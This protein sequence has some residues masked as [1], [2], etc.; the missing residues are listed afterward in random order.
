MFLHTFAH[1]EGQVEAAEIRVRRFEQINYAQT[2]LIVFKTAVLAHALGQHLFPRMA[3]GGVTKIVPKRDRFGQIFI[4][5]QGPRNGAT[6]RGN[7]D[8]M[9]Q[10][11]A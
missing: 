2:L 5:T 1:L 9:G 6:D 11:R 4:Q 8:S 7:L 3:E 10:A